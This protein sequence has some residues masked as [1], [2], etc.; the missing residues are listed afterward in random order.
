MF[1]MQILLPLVLVHVMLLALVVVYP[2]RISTKPKVFVIGLSKTGTTSMG[3]ALAQ[4]NYTRLGW[5]DIYSRYLVITTF[6]V[7]PAL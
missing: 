6:L 3:D 4:L 1:S 7:S 2:P 5:S